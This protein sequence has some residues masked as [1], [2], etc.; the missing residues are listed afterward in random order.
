M[1]S[2]PNALKQITQ[3]NIHKL[4][5]WIID[6]PTMEEYQ[7]CLLS[8]ERMPVYVWLPELIWPDDFELTNRKLPCPCCL[9][10]E[11]VE[12][13]EYVTRRFT[14]PKTWCVLLGRRYRCCG[15]D[16]YSYDSE[17]IKRLP[18]H[19]RHKFPLLLTHKHGIHLD[20]VNDVVSDTLAGKSISA[21]HNAV[22]ARHHETFRKAY[23]DYLSRCTQLLEIDEFRGT[24]V[25]PFGDFSDPAKYAGEFPSEGYFGD[26]YKLH[27]EQPL[28]SLNSLKSFYGLEGVLDH[29]DLE[30]LMKTMNQM[31]T[32]V[33][34][35]RQMQLR[36]GSQISWD[37]T[38]NIAR[39]TQVR[40]S[41][42]TDPAMRSSEGESVNAYITIFTV[43]NE[44]GQIILVMATRT[45]SLSE[46]EE[47]LKA[48]FARMRANNLPIPQ[49]IFT[50]NCCA[51]RNLIDRI[52]KSLSEK[53]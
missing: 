3:I 37:A 34:F 18:A 47:E 13:I 45:T 26:V 4:N 29:Q 51:E 22:L 52:I 17:V 43:F 44:I 31:T 48:M 15:Q 40:Q 14:G 50:D 53:D 6:P 25:E 12:I 20:I 36:G 42:V 19:I 33:Y 41:V 9:K 30:M 32:K 11:N 46:I 28:F 27:Q 35:A 10:G 8:K 39:L 7:A 2:V 49:V 23:I 16:F 21:T 24:V 5:K 1:T 38:F